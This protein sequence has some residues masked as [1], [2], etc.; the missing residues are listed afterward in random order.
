MVKLFAVIF[1]E[2]LLLWRDK[3]GLLVLFAM[4][5]VLVIVVSLV[6]ENVLKTIG[7][8]SIKIL[9]VNKDKRSL[10]RI[11]GEKL[12]ESDSAAVVK[13][14]DSH[15]ISEK[16]A[17]EAVVNKDFQLCIIIP[18]GMTEAV[19]AQA[20]R[21]VMES[22]SIEDSSGE[23]S[24]GRKDENIPEIVVYFDPIIHGSFR[25]AVLSSLDRVILGLEIKEK[26]KILSEFL[27]IKIDKAIQKA[28]G[29]H[30]PEKLIKDVS[31]IDFDWSNEQV[32]KVKEK[33]AF[34]N[35]FE[36][37]P[38]SVQQNVPAWA[39]FGIFFIIVPMSGSLI[40]ERQTGTLARILTMPVS[41]FTLISGKVAAYVLICLIQFVLILLIGMFLL[42]FLGTPKFEMGSDPFAITVITLAA[43]LAATG[44]GV[45]LGTI[46]ETYEQ[47]S[48]F[49]SISVVIA[50]ALG[51]IMV[52]V[53][54]MPR[55]MQKISAFSPLEWGMDAFLDIFVR[56]GS[57]ATV[58]FDV[59]LLLF[60]F[61][62]TML[63]SW[64][65]FFRT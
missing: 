21:I 6:Q 55:L 7:K 38:T 26:V 46:A 18:K 43:I 64:I 37:L 58:I 12:S 30:L 51:G 42:P 17:V 22:L 47:A 20:K 27:P 23:D 10:S 56:N 33:F 4:P 2:L 65:Y 44:Y 8:S 3:T 49:G 11:I 59:G 63:I 32:V 53:F 29:F 52:P 40:N 28:A 15:E 61:A 34:H 54:A 62:A 36:K 35:G 1:K 31:A 60:F 14:I 24:S 45:M 13:Q 50:G 19:K 9:F 16:A 48:M 25:S 57:I 5:A 39:L 41:Y